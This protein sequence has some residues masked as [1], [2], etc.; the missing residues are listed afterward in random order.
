M[1]EIIK[2]NDNVNVEIKRM[3]GRTIIILDRMGKR[4]ILSDLKTS[5]TFT[6]HVVRDDNYIV[7]YSKNSTMNQMPL[8]IECAY[9]IKTDT[10]LNTKKNPKLAKDLEMMLI[11]KRSFD[12][13][14]IIL[15]LNEKVTTLKSMDD[16][17]E[18]VIYLDNGNEAIYGEMMSYVLKEYPVLK[19][20]L[21]VEDFDYEK[22]VEELGGEYLSFHKMPQIIDTEEDKAQVFNVLATRK[23]KPYIISE[24]EL[25]PTDVS[26]KEKVN[27]MAQKFK[28]NNLVRVRRRDVPR[29]N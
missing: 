25:Q 5:D 17:Y 21:N 20:Y 7:V 22:A 14:T 26:K 10:F 9:N 23:K 1:S 6:S 24:E 3:K 11:S 12:I 4:V 15:W 13:I 16:I 29:T 18:F 28:K 19:K 2:I 27:K 8:E